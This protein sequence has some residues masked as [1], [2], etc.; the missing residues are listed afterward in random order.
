MNVFGLHSTTNHRNM[1]KRML[2]FYEPNLIKIDIIIVAR[3][4]NML[5]ILMKNVS[6]MFS[7]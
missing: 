5:T 1:R 3:V 6:F 4:E 7:T 2:R